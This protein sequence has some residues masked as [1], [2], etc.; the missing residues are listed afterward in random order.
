MTH[1]VSNTAQTYITNEGVFLQ[2]QEPRIESKQNYGGVTQHAT[3]NDDAI[4]I[5]RR[6][7]D[8]SRKDEDIA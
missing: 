2:V 7:L 3:H 5:W 1:T 8:N 6:H 4:E